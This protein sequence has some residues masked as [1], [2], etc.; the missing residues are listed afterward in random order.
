MISEIEKN[1]S[2]KFSKSIDS[3]DNEAII[4]SDIIEQLIN[5]TLEIVKQRENLKI[6]E[7]GF[8]TGLLTK[9]L[10]CCFSNSEFTLNDIIKN[11]A[12]KISLLCN[13]TNNTFNFHFGNAENFQSN[14][15][16]DLIASSST[17]H[18]F[19]NLE[20][21]INSIN[22]Y[23]NSKGYLIFST[24]GTDNCH[25][26]TDF[27]EKK[28]KY[29][30]LE[31]IREFVKPN[32]DIIYEYEYKKS[33]EFCSVLEVLLH[34]KKTG[35]NSLGKNLWTKKD[36]NNFL[37]N[38]PIHNNKILLTYNPIIIIAKKR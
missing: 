38:Y 12:E 22:K 8:G 5:K 15:K 27:I 23:L 13:E 7:I 21:F 31:Q 20:L 25:E 9:K 18:W 30:S 28:L 1:I 36:L 6:L 24:F 14:K 10:N 2:G 37:N 4:Q 35:V 16:F 3:Y 11:T 32:F 17:F 33:L 34:L 19:S 26:L 29:H